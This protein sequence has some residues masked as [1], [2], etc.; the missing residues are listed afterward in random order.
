M[1]A[2]YVLSIVIFV[3]FS[4][5]QIRQSAAPGWVA[6]YTFPALICL[7]E[8][9]RS[10]G[11]ALRKPLIIAGLALYLIVFSIH[12][13]RGFDALQTWFDQENGR[14]ALGALVCFSLLLVVWFANP[15]DRR[16]RRGRSTG[17]RFSS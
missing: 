5:M 10:A 7:L 15:D 1:K 11:Y 8:I 4:W 17:A 3:A 9:I 12:F 6:L 13:P 14:E 16:R 2:F